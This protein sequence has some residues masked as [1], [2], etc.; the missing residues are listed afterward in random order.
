MSSFLRDPE[1]ALSQGGSEGAVFPGGRE[2]QRASSEPA[3]LCP[4]NTG[5]RAGYLSALVVGFYFHPDKNGHFL[6]VK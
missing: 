2:L 3:R 1:A 5:R 4:G 6:N